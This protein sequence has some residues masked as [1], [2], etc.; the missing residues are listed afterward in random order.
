VK[1]RW[2]VV[3]VAAALGSACTSEATVGSP[4]AS[5]VAETEPA[6]TPEPATTAHPAEP[7]TGPIDTGPTGQGDENERDENEEESV[8]PTVGTNSAT[9][10]RSTIATDAGSIDASYAG[11]RLEVDIR[12]K[13]GWSADV[14]RHSPT[15]LEVVWT[16]D[17]GSVHAEVEAGDAGISSSTRSVTSS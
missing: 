8:P 10:S 4:N 1:P 16:S 5:S 12:S 13:P 14:H 2:L 17:R 9:Q 15:R 7:D 11:G 3:L 6:G